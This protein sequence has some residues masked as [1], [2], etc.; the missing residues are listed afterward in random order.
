MAASTVSLTRDAAQVGAL[1]ATPEIA[2]LIGQLQE[3]RWTGPPGYPLRAMVGLTLIKS[4]YTLPTW[5]RTVALV[6]DHAGLR[7]VLGA[8]TGSLRSFGSTATCSPRAS[9]T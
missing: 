8:R 2:R 3:T 4:L 7:D 6:R 9:M 1:L 5:T